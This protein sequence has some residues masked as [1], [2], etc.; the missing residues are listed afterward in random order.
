[1]IQLFS[2]HPLGPAIKELIPQIAPRPIFFVAA[3]AA[4]IEA[5]LA[6]RYY[7]LADENAQL[8][9]VPDAD[10]LAGIVDYPQEYVSKMVEFFDTNLLGGD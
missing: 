3:Q 2:G 4:Q 10:H 7:Q 1:M 6:R 5:A 8:W 9:V